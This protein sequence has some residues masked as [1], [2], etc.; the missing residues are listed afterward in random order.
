MPRASVWVV[1]VMKR[2]ELL[3]MKT[4]S[5]AMPP[6]QRTWSVGGA[7]T[8]DTP[9]VSDRTDRHPADLTQTRPRPAGNRSHPSARIL[10]C[11]TAAAPDG[12]V[13][14][15]GLQ[16]SLTRDEKE[17]QK[18]V[19]QGYVTTVGV[20]RLGERPRQ[21][22]RKMRH[23]HRRALL[24]IQSFPPTPDLVAQSVATGWGSVPP[25]TP[26]QSVADAC[27]AG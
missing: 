1:C 20:C 8:A 14:A 4:F 27:A 16:S 12:R 2:L 10:E 5:C 11:Y 25:R 7:A 13:A 26:S 19:A 9:N 6:G 18:L 24:G 17:C 21:G 15:V 3:P 22:A 23:T